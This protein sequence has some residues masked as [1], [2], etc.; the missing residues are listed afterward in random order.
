MGVILFLL[1]I[2]IG[3]RYL[4]TIGA[5]HIKSEKGDGKGGGGFEEKGGDPL[6]F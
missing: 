3:K 6:D 4:S 1:S 2:F 5:Q